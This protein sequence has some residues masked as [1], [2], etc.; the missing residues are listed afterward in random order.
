MEEVK[1]T[2]VTYSGG[3]WILQFFVLCVL[4][5]TLVGALSYTIDPFS[6]RETHLLE[7]ARE[8][9]N[10]RTNVALWAVCETKRVPDQHIS[11]AEIIILG[12]SRA[13]LLTNQFENHRMA[14]MNGQKI[15]NLCIG[16][17]SLE[18][19]LTLFQ[20]EEDRAS[21]FASL[22]TVV[23]STPLIRFCEPNRPNRL[24]QSLKLVETPFRYYLNDL[25]VRRSFVSLFR[26]QA[27]S[28][29]LPVDTDDQTVLRAWRENYAGYHSQTFEQRLSEVA[30]FL[31]SLRKRGIQVICYVPP[32]AGGNRDAVAEADLFEV[33][34]RFTDRLVKSSEFHDLAD[35]TELKGKPF[36]YQAGDPI[37]HD[38][39]GE[40]LELLPASGKTRN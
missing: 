11:N 26:Y 33:R 31:E 35:L 16:G 7:L 30:L 22:K 1:E 32:G 8:N 13:R 28:V 25:I 23:I 10:R 15:Y 9:I 12:D 18:E 3:R 14:S 4:A 38:R 39:G 24:V 2:K 5:L 6:L 29:P 17:A 27:K 19:C 21:G 36:S 34:K 37:H 20:S 40:I